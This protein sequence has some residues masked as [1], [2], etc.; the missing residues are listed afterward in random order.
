MKKVELKNYRT[1]LRQFL[2]ISL[3][4]VLL[5][6]CAT[7]TAEVPADKQDTELGESGEPGDEPGS[8]TSSNDSSEF[9]YSDGIDENGFWKGIKALDYVEMFNYKGLPIPREVHY[10]S[11]EAIN[12]EIE[13]MLT[14]FSTNE[15]IYDRA[16]VDGDKVNIDYVGSIDGVE[17]DGGSTGGM[18]TDVTAGSL[19]YIDDF[20]IQII[21]HKPGETI[22]VKVTFPADYHAEELAGKDALFVTTINYIAGEEVK[23]ELTDDFVKENLYYMGGWTSI[24]EMKDGLRSDMQKYAIQEYINEYFTNQ[25]NVKSVPDY[26]AKY[27]ELAMVN[28]FEQ[29][30]KQYNMEFDEFLMN[31][32]GI[33]G[34]D[35]LI[36]NYRD[37]NFA[38][39]TSSLIVQAVAESEG[40][41]LSTDDIRNYFKEN[42]GTEDYSE[43]IEEF[44]LPYIKQNI[45][46]IK[47][48]D[49]ILENA[50]LS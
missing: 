49:L 47:I 2:A 42:A 37:D 7:K 38:R 36:A 33:S 26:V 32:Q 41:K 44:G 25:V 43:Y 13:N 18:G 16:I 30:A 22:D 45:M 48:M 11:E 9:S 31:M 34:K 3:L 20:L 39:A 23:A 29:N 5:A 12:S 28:W 17:F 1:Y 8:G 6:G 15:K 14:R 4:L 19:D 10:V 40:F 35:E 27:Q 50:V 24:K 21:G 46:Y